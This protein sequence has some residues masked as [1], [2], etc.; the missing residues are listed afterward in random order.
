[1]E[2]FR[3]S[4]ILA[5]MVRV[6]THPMRLLAL[7]YGAD[8][9]FTEEIID[10]KLCNTQL[11]NN[12]TVNQSLPLPF[13]TELLNTTDFVGTDNA[14]VFRTSHEERHKVFLQLGTANP[15]KA[16]EAAKRVE[17]HVAG[18][19]VNMGC[20]KDYSIK[21]GMGAALLHK[22]DLIKAILSTLVDNLHIPVSC[23]IRL[24]PSLED[25]LKL[26][27]LIESCGVCALTVHG[28][29]KTEKPSD[30]CRL[31]EIKRIAEA[32]AI[33]VIAKYAFACVYLCPPSGGSKEHIRLH[34]DIAFF[35]QQ[36]GASGVMLARAAMWNPA[37]FSPDP[38]QRTQLEVAR[39]YLKLVLFCINYPM[40]SI[41]SSLSRV[42]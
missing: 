41:H 9:V 4:V 36:T 13:H 29:R 18:V 26:A 15:E 10:Y 28:R 30:T 14:I 20:P 40:H 17:K 35:R 34:D 16:L 12:G 31:E 38:P 27:R 7:S 24:L 6:S 32:L 37:I 22:P 3:D 23:K 25:T 33:P 42:Q 1:M 11:I 19:D 2:I 8:L 39:Q 5:P 21:G